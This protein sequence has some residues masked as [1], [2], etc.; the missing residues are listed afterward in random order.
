[1]GW[2]ET[3]RTA[4][5]ALN[6]RRM[7][8]LLTM[9]GILIGIAAVMLTVGLGEGA[10]KQ[11]G[12]EI[13][14]LGSNLLIV[15]PG[16]MSAD[17]PMMRGGE[18]TMSLT[19]D[20]AELIS[21]PQVAPDVAGV[22]PMASTRA[23]AEHGTTSW[24]TTVT[25][26]NTLWQ[27]VRSREMLDGRFFTPEEEARADSVAVLGPTT[28]ARLFGEA[29]AVG[30]TILVQHQR[31]TVI[32]VLEGVGSGSMSND[33]D[34]IVVPLTSFMQRLQP[35]GTSRQIQAI[36]VA[37]QDDDS[38]ASAHQQ[39]TRALVVSHRTT[40]ADQDFTIL[41]FQALMSA[42]GAMTGV[43]TTLLSGIAG[44]SLL[45]GGIGV[46]NIMLVSVSE[47]VREIGLRKALG[48][49]P[50]LIRR[51]FL[52]EAS[53]VGLAGGFLGIVVGFAGAAALTPL[54]DIEVT[55]SL[56]ATLIALTVSLG[57][58][59]IAGVYP[60]SRAAKLA[61]IDALRNE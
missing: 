5:E 56:P 30:N 15:M 27:T 51:Q 60:A 28:A 39:I 20:D 57:V 52:V 7:R 13:A 3:L 29:P 48:A 54:L 49:T 9:L 61:P 37:A 22:A 19:L 53:L 46:M 59:L 25:G 8:T 32:G 44:I 58:G 16:S 45:V 31:F 23:A 42:A 11:I 21:D 40:A 18:P 10:K 26:T 38:I 14:K 47:R 17:S 4:F 1:M 34:Q 50:G 41:T 12:T 36:F 6:G 33:D 55:L 2:G 24:S 43:L 35:M